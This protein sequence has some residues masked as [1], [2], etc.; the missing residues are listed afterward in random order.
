MSNQDTAVNTTEVADTSTTD[1][2]PVETQTFDAEESLENVDIS[3]ELLGN[4]DDSDAKSDDSDST[5]E[6]DSKADNDQ[7]TTDTENTDQADETKTEEP[8]YTKA[9]QRKEQLNSEIREMVELKK[10]YEQELAQYQQQQQQSQDQPF[11]EE[12]LL[13]EINPD[14]GEYFT[15]TEARVVMMQQE[16]QQMRQQAQEKE[17]QQQVQQSRMQLAHDIENAVKE[18]P[19]F[20]ARSDSYD[21]ALAEKA[22]RIIEANLVMDNNGQPV[23]SRIPIREILATFAEVQQ[24]SVATGEAKARQATNKML[25]NVDTAGGSS[26]ATSQKRDAYLEAFDSEF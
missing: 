26:G 22:K 11:T 19:M 13:N 10:Q 12:Q 17:Y 3:A 5:E 23:S 25:A 1:S 9:E 7:D 18:Y 2:A 4:D 8:Q 16:V 14:T 20:N 21:K 6:T 15:P 24:S